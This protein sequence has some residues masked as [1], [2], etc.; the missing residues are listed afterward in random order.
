MV[1]DEFQDMVFVA[2]AGLRFS[3]LLVNEV[4]IEPNTNQQFV[5]IRQKDSK[6]RITINYFQCIPGHKT[7]DC[8]KEMEKLNKSKNLEKAFTT[9]EGDTIY[10][11]KKTNQR[12]TS[13]D[14]R[15]GYYISSNSQQF[16]KEIIPLMDFISDTF[17]DTYIAPQ[18]T[19]ICTDTT[20]N[21]VMSTITSRNQLFFDELL[22]IDVIG[23]DTNGKN[24]QCF[25]VVDLNNAL[26][27]SLISI[28]YVN[29]DDRPVSTPSNTSGDSVANDEVNDGQDGTQNANED[30]TENDGENGDES[31]TDQEDNQEDTQDDEGANGASN[32]STASS[33]VQQFPLKLED[34]FVHTFNAGYTVSFPSKNI[35]F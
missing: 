29:P 17:I 28:D 30:N 19:S 20:N 11:I 15:F 32:P 34:P 14:D 31:D 21:I 2:Q 25:V 9:K 33:N 7:Y 23:K 12:Y 8:K 22:S 5:T 10:R 35:S 18:L 26:G 24:L 6:N 13:I 1:I 4:S 27:G 3:D 16:V